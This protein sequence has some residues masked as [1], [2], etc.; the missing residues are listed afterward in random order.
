MGAGGSVSSTPSARSGT[1]PRGT[2]ISPWNYCAYFADRRVSL[3]TTKFDIISSNSQWGGDP[4]SGVAKSVVVLSSSSILNNNI[5]NCLFIRENASFSWN[6]EILVLAA[7]YGAQADVTER[8]KSMVTGN[9]GSFTV[10]N[11]TMG[12]DPLIG[13]PKA[14]HILYVNRSDVQSPLAYTDLIC[15][16]ASEQGHLIY[17]GGDYLASGI[18]MHYVNDNWDKLKNKP[19]R[20]VTMLG[21]HDAGMSQCNTLTEACQEKWVKTQRYSLKDQLY[22]GVRYFDLRIALWDHG[23][24]GRDNDIWQ[25]AINPDWKWV[26]YHFAEPPRGL[27][28][29]AYGEPLLSFADSLNTFCSVAKTLIFLNC[30]AP[31]QFVKNNKTYAVFD[32]YPSKETV[33]GS[34]NKTTNLPAVDG[35]K[36]GM[37]GGRPYEYWNAL[38]TDVF[39]NRVNNLW[40]SSS[41]TM[42]TTY[43]ELLGKRIGQSN[44]YYLARS[45]IILIFGVEDRQTPKRWITPEQLNI[46]G[47]Y[48]N[49]ND[50]STMY[51]DQM[52]KLTHD[53]RNKFFVFHAEL[54]QQNA[55][56]TD[57]PNHD[58]DISAGAES[59]INQIQTL[60]VSPDLDQYR[61]VPNNQVITVMLMDFVDDR[62]RMLVE[63]MNAQTCDAL[64]KTYNSRLTINYRGIVMVI[65]DTTTDADCRYAFF[66]GKCIDYGSDKS[67]ILPNNEP[68]EIKTFP[69]GWSIREEIGV[70]I[71]RYKNT[72]ADN[73]Y[74]FYPGNSQNFGP[75]LATVAVGITRVLYRTPN[76]V[77]QEENGALCIR[78]TRN[79]GD[80]RFAFFTSNYVDM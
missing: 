25:P 31:R 42:D 58:Y 45:R 26:T 50:F 33:L 60:T 43:Q 77:I 3:P 4:C 37:Y 27:C 78:D 28:A 36:D 16:F 24:I 6:T 34:G 57:I 12:T 2:L 68:V 70:L 66:P 67:K 5:V 79:P 75:K 46:G 11:N 23:G 17:N 69:N 35:N 71:F 62:S 1:I 59:T 52:E 53:G 49:T 22:L 39:Q 18:P 55:P 7:I 72:T 9:S 44:E 64:S 19:L 29:G 73:R 74:A 48:S 14:L 54:T 30:S 76:W 13:C 41:I 63:N 32:L 40:K 51:K 21:S 8:V 15:T 47:S 56:G 80:N 65:E 10:N 20:R 61:L 38:Y